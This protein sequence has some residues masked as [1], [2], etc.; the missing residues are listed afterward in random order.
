MFMP[1]SPRPPRG[2]AK[3]DCRGLLNEMSAPIGTGEEYHSA[4]ERNADPALH[5]L[6]SNSVNR[7]SFVAGTPSTDRSH[8]CIDKNTSVPADLQLREAVKLPSSGE[9]SA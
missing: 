7:F 5:S 1:N 9:Q 8:N 6:T 4:I 2:I 3:S